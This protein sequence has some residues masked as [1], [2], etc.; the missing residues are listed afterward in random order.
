MTLSRE[1]RR[2]RRKKAFAA[3]LPHVVRVVRTQAR[4]ARDLS[5]PKATICSDNIATVIDRGALLL[6][7]KDRQY[8]SGV[9]GAAFVEAARRGFIR[10]AGY[11]RNRYASLVRAWRAA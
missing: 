6:A 8:K 9:F 10:P 1:E 5:G 11:T 2:A 3:D 4:K 7:F